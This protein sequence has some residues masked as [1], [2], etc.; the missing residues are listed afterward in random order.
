LSAP[1]IRGLSLWQP[2]A[3]L[4]ATR[5]KRIETRSWET[6]YRGWVAIQATKT[7]PDKPSDYAP[8]DPLRR[9]IREKAGAHLYATWLAGTLPVGAIVAV[10]LLYH[11]GRISE[12]VD[13]RPAVYGEG[14]TT[15]ID[16]G[17]YEEAFGDYTPGRYGWCFS[18]MI[19]LPEPVPCRGAQQLWRV[20]DDALPA[21]VEVLRRQGCV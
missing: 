11:V 6:N 14:S 4:L 12:G 19:E 13:G 8:T 18:T 2:W 15:L 7:S 3:S 10:G 9:A 1:I 5:A 20:P 21:L 17:A 16:V